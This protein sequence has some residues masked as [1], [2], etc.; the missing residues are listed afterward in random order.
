MVDLQITDYNEHIPHSASTL[1]GYNWT[2]PEDFHVASSVNP[3]DGPTNN[4][5]PS[6]R[7]MGFPGFFIGS[8]SNN[9][10]QMDQSRNF[11]A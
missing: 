3:P 7:Q 6:S 11:S 4:T 9:E 5:S 2:F 8:Q 10:K 1:D